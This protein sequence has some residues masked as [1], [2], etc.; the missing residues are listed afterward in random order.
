MTAGDVLASPEEEKDDATDADAKPTRGAEATELLQRRPDA[1]PDPAVATS[2]S[3]LMDASLKS[4]E[5]RA[6]WLLGTFRADAAGLA[7]AVG[8]DKKSL[9]ALFRATA[10]HRL[11][12]QRWLLKPL[13]AKIIQN[14]ESFHVDEI[15]CLARAM[16]QVGYLRTDFLYAASTA[17]AKNAQVASPASC[18]LL[19]EAF[20]A[21]RLQS[22]QA[23]RALCGQLRH[24]AI[25][26]LA[27]PQLASVISS[28][29]RLNVRNA[30]LLATASSRL[31]CLWSNP[32]AASESGREAP[33][34]LGRADGLARPTRATKPERRFFPHDVAQVIYGLTKLQ[35]NHPLMA[36]VLRDILPQVVGRMH[37]HQLT[38]TAVAIQRLREHSR[39]VDCKSGGTWPSDARTAAEPHVSG[40]RMRGV[41]CPGG[42]EKQRTLELLQDSAFGL[43]VNEV[44]KRLPQFK[45]ESICMVLRACAALG[46]KDN[47]LIA[48]LV[49]QLPRLL[50]TFDPDDVV[51][52]TDS[53]ARLGLHSG[54]SVDLI[55]LHVRQNSNRYKQRHLQ[56][57]LFSFSRE[58]IVVAEYLQL[59]ASSTDFSRLAHS[60][61]LIAVAC[62]LTDCGFR[63]SVVVRSMSNELRALLP[64]LSLDDLSNVHA[65]FVLLGVGDYGIDLHEIVEHLS[66]RLRS[67][68]HNSAE[69]R[70]CLGTR[71]LVDASP[72]FPSMERKNDVAIDSPLGPE[73]GST[74]CVAFSPACTPQTLS[75][76]AALNLTI[77]LLLVEGGSGRSDGRRFREQEK[78]QRERHEA[79]LEC[80][81]EGGIRLPLDPVLLSSDIAVFCE[82]LRSQSSGDA[83]ESSLSAPGKDAPSSSFLSVEE[84]RKLALLRAALRLHFENDHA[85]H[86]DGRRD[87]RVALAMQVVERLSNV[88]PS[89]VR[90]P[91]A[92]PFRLQST[93]SCTSPLRVRLGIGRTLRPGDEGKSLPDLFSR[94]PSA[95]DNPAV[96][97]PDRSASAEACRG[98][99]VAGHR[100]SS[101]T[102][103]AEESKASELQSRALRKVPGLHV[104]FLESGK[105]LDCESSSAFASERPKAPLEP[106]T[107]FPCPYRSLSFIERSTQSGLAAVQSVLQEF[108]GV[109]S[110][111]V[112]ACGGFFPGNQTTR[113]S[114][115]L[116]P[117][118]AHAQRTAESHTSDS[119]T[120]RDKKNAQRENPRRDASTKAGDCSPTG[121][122]EQ[123]LAARQNP[124]TGY[125][126]LGPEE[127]QRLE[128]A[129]HSATSFSSSLRVQNR[130]RQAVKEQPDAC[131][132]RPVQP[133]S[134]VPSPV[135]RPS[136]NGVI[137]LW[138][139][140]QHFWHGGPRKRD[141][142]GRSSR[143]PGGSEQRADK[144]VDVVT[145]ASSNE[146]AVTPHRV[147]ENSFFV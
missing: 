134:A 70:G 123:S 140:A 78:M 113:S 115:P 81:R 72:A 64:V 40:E 38:I 84:Q 63:N 79:D 53:L 118:A 17:I 85:R 147:F 146:Y 126:Y 35:C 47:R 61:A 23:V 67:G 19:L 75:L 132:E 122:G 58:G 135:P 59:Y 54:A 125:L 56:D 133:N 73:P 30:Q 77:S 141:A 16:H 27:P 137:L 50:S 21:H 66:Q 46:V 129:F 91:A 57:L 95:G 60:Q 55:I 9:I 8:D 112:D 89:V 101:T 143:N 62:A 2:V 107:E 44:A 120:S 110:T 97:Q 15:A 42:T 69:E 34:P 82:Q 18:C 116:A 106:R 24:H 117:R 100:Q 7:A 31:L 20:A 28:L 5:T 131:T 71:P 90:Q 41:D 114:H 3:C 48:R 93:V 103:A 105:E 74:D 49:V 138:G 80:L 12:R 86:L 111:I 76:S 83:S 51:V 109:G 104:P 98:S 33:A 124:Y 26:G 87:E 119:C 108:F 10:L 94:F 32:C 121:A 11:T 6:Q 29:A 128:A 1:S 145:R 127:T 65:A 14:I 96:G 36:F 25:R 88:V 102:R 136:P 142:L 99:A 4:E 52:L 45:A 144:Q 43:V 37:S 39:A 68:V 22:E 130:K 139:D 92:I 13:K